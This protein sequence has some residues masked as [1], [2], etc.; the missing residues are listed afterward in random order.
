[1]YTVKSWTVH[2]DP[3]VEVRAMTVGAEGVCNP[4]GRTT[5]SSNQTLQS[6]PDLNHQP[7]CTQGI[8][9]APNGYVAEDCLIWDH[10]EGIPV[11]VGCP[12]VGES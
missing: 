4:I 8:P 10:W 9:M 2:G 3:N 12:R 11:E 7:K 6:S 5:K 1:M